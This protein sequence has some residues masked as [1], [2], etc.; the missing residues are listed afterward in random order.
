MAEK[1][2]AA[3]LV[4]LI[5][6]PLEKYPAWIEPVVLP[7]RGMMLFGA[8]SKAGKSLMAMEACRA[9]GTGS[10]LFGYGGF[11]TEE[12]RVLYVEAEVGVYGLHGRASKVFADEDVVRIA[13]NVW[14]VS[15]NPDLML[16]TELGLL[17]LC[18]EVDRTQANVVILDP[19]SSMFTVDENDASG[20]TALFNRLERLRRK[21]RQNDLSIIM[22]HHFGKPPTGKF[23]DSYDHLSFHNFRGSSKFFSVPDTVCTAWRAEELNLGWESW[24]LKARWVC[25]QGESPPEMYLNVNAQQDLRVRWERNSL[26]NR[27]PQGEKELKPVRFSPAS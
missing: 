24:R 2:P 11:R 16:D 19:I 17:R 3:R 14:Y 8:H 22:V 21:F 23:S 9:L 25:R 10:N 26:G 12:C 4:D 6:Q 7:K 15:Q 18:D 20:M 1:N 5:Q 27:K 13:D